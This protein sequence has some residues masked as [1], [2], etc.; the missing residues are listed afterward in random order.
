MYTVETLHVSGRWDW[1]ARL[2]TAGATI[3][4]CYLLQ[5]N[6]IYLYNNCMFM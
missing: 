3:I 1:K 5:E 4:K 2:Y 6:Y